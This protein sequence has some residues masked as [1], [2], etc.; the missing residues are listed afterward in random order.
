MYLKDRRQLRSATA[1]RSWRFASSKAMRFMKMTSI[2]LLVTCLGVSATTFPQTIT[3]S[4]KKAPLEKIFKEIKIQS[5]Y[6]FFYDP[7]VIKTALPVDI[8]VEKAGLEEVLNICF[9]NQPLEYSISNKVI[10]VNA[11]GPKSAPAPPFQAPPLDVKGKIV[12]EEGNPLPGAS[13][14]V[15]G[16]DKGTA[17]DG[18]GNF[19]L[20]VPD[21]KSVLIVSFIGYQ[22]REIAANATLSI[23]LKR[24]ETK[25]NDIV[26][27][28]YGTK[29]KSDLTG[30]LSYVSS[31]DFENQP[32]TRLDQAL[33]GRAT[34]VQVTSASGS[35]GGDV[36]I[37]IR[38]ANSLTGDNNP[39]Y[40][41]D[42]FVGADF[43]N[44]NTEDIASIVVLKDAS[45]TAI[46]GS[47]GANGVIIITTK[48]G[49]AGKM[50][51]SLMSRFSASNVIDR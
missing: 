24:E 51:V 19:N 30:S 36:R 21:G 38:G 37:R 9:K 16:M 26:V 44:I 34:G 40:V 6:L 49:K 20:Q 45:S 32:V 46:Y 18:N 28:G 7:D 15:K 8:K 35:P 42:G 10:V 1:A 41:V 31:K 13:V 43:N 23:V 50:Q 12:D 5:G 29:K 17:T 14:K 3:L 48:G 4:E 33:Q 25:M 2:M 27:I 11:K 47:R 22:T 39:L